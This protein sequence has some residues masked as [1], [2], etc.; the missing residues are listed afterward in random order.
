MCSLS[1]T[2]AVASCSGDGPV[3]G[4]A[5]RSR[6]ARIIARVHVDEAA[7]EPDQI[8]ADHVVGRGGGDD[9]AQR[10]PVLAPEPAGRLDAR[11]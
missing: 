10:R 1:R 7:D 4:A 5:P 11:A 2:S 6:S 3:S 8:V 9:A